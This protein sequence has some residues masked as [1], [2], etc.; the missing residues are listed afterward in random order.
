MWRQ[1]SE[2]WS[3]TSRLR[4]QRKDGLSLLVDE[5]TAGFSDQ[6]R[7][8]NIAVRQKKTVMAA[9]RWG[10]LSPTLST[11]WPGTVT[12]LMHPNLVIGSPSVVVNE[13]GGEKFVTGCYLRS[14]SKPSQ[15]E[16]MVVC[17]VFPKDRCL[18]R[19]WNSPHPAVS[20][21]CS[22]YADLSV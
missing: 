10:R 16:D 15:A 6:I 1:L 14:P 22:V 8:F 2:I 11:N 3:K 20:V 7:D 18:S 12:S 5:L 21:P 4:C 13:A 17:R 9:S 19:N